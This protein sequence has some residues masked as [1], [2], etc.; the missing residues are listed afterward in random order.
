MA[1]GAS[2]L[3]GFGFEGY[4][5]D[6]KEKG[7]KGVENI[8]IMGFETATSVQSISRHWNKRTQVQYIHSYSNTIIYCNYLL[9]CAEQGLVYCCDYVIVVSCVW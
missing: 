8:D 1:E 9:Y 2:I 5:A 6:G 7:W 3:G 4:T